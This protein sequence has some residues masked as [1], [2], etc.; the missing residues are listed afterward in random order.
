VRYQEVK[1][2]DLPPFH[3]TVI[4]PSPAWNTRR[5]CH[6]GFT[7]RSAL[8]ISL[9]PDQRAAVMLWPRIGDVPEDTLIAKTDKQAVVGQI[10]LLELCRRS[11]SGAP[12]TWLSD[13]ML[14]T[15]R[16]CRKLV[17]LHGHF[18]SGMKRCG[19]PQNDGQFAMLREQRQRVLAKPA[20][21]DRKRSAC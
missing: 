2:V 1:D 21:G 13:R 4:F 15:R 14:K 11:G 12:R 17:C 9:P 19:I 8:W 10:L 6:G 3:E 7:I 16:P 18:A 5:Q 20:G